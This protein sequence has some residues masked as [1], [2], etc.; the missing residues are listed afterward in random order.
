[1]SNGASLLTPQDSAPTDFVALAKRWYPN[2]SIKLL[3]LVWQGYG[4]LKKELPAGTDERDLERSITQSL[5]IRIRRVMSGDEPFDIQ[6][7]PYERETMQPPPAQPPQYDLAFILRENERIMWPLEAKVLET[8]TALSEY[9]KDL[10]NEFL[11]CRY[12]PFSSQ[13]AMLAYLL[14]GN[15]D[16][17]F[18]GIEA[19]VPCQLTPNPSFPTRPCRM[20]DHLRSV[21]AGKRYASSLRCHHLVLEFLGLSRAKRKKTHKK[22]LRT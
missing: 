22:A 9:V 2:L 19:K 10:K 6:H 8:D 14:R 11:T 16:R 15:P 1:M 17:V 3:D 4:F 12:S 7:G 13:A 5:E 20:S 18:R 21:P